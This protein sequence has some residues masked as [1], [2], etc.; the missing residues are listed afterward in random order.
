MV[1]HKRNKRSRL[2]GRK[3]CGWGSRKKHRGKGSHGGKGMA[4]TGKRADHHKTLIW[5]T[6]RE[7][8][9]GKRGFHSKF[10]KFDSIN[11]EDIEKRLNDFIKEG[12]AKKTAAGIEINLENMKVLG[13]LG[14]GELKNK[15]IIKARSFSENAKEIIEAAGGKA[16]SEEKKVVIKKA[17]A[18][19][20]GEEKLKKQPV[21]QKSGKASKLK[22]SVLPIETKKMEK[23]ESKIEDDYIEEKKEME[24]P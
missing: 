11:I 3:T 7:A 14:N 16:I 12:K 20:S 15:L 22:P 10:K 6:V 9:W 19:E 2:R 23:A 4:G 5:N 13:K 18:K 8:Y 21:Q 17:P 24:E 1:N